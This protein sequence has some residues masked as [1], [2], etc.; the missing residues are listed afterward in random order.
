MNVAVITPHLPTLIISAVVA[1]IVGIVIGRWSLQRRL[2]AMRVEQTRLQT[3]L[4]S[5]RRHTEERISEL[6]QARQSMADSF[7]ALSREALKANN[8]EFLRVARE[9]LEQ[10]QI[11]AAN[12]LGE[13]EQSIANLVK[14]ISATLEKTE[15]QLRQMEKERKESFGAIRTILEQVT[16]SQQDL[17][18]ETRR[19]V[20]ALRRPE[21]RGQW[22]ELTLRRL[23]EIAGM[24][25]HCDFYEQPHSTDGDGAGIRPD[26]VIRMPE[27]REIVVD[28]KTPLDSYLN[29][30]EADSDE[31]RQQHLK[32]HAL[33]VRERIRELSSKAYWSQFARSPDFVVLF[34][35][36]DQFLSAAIDVDS[37]LIEDALRQK[38]VVATPT[39]FIALLRAVAFGWRQLALAENAEQIRD[40]GEE[41]YKRLATFTEHLNRLGK[42]LGS[43]V[44]HYNKAVG[45]LERQVIPGARR[46][47]EMGIKAAKDIPPLDPLDHTTRRIDG[48]DLPDASE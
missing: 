22:G 35:P 6:H 17:Q 10:F 16:L 29:A 18:T 12:Q 3:T 21:V 2:S 4:D 48:S 41:L 7:S 38:V 46:F 15:Q 28:V 32:K 25:D 34:I 26:M 45:S 24:V 20:Q 33:K 1:L 8:E 47:P 31:H 30:L 36:G 43:S 19:L 39:S 37:Q 14:P 23:A 40:L 42:S 44:D 5:E 27:N 13:R 11:K 9:R